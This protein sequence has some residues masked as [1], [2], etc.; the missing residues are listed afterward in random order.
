MRPSRVCTFGLKRRS[1]E[2]LDASVAGVRIATSFGVTQLAN[3]RMLQEEKKLKERL[4]ALPDHAN[5]D[6][7]PQNLTDLFVR[8]SA[9]E[10]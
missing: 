4:I 5:D 3:Y 9:F 1:D 6:S 10:C 2:Q 7:P 8:L